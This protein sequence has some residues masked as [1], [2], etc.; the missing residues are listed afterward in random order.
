MKETAIK[1]SPTKTA[2][3]EFADPFHVR[4]G[5]P[6][7]RTITTPKITKISSI[8]APLFSQY[9]SHPHKNKSPAGELLPG[10]DHFSRRANSRPSQKIGLGKAI[11]IGD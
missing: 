1:K 10:A 2:R 3:N 5:S 7:T 8:L 9:L 11:N 6:H 4:S